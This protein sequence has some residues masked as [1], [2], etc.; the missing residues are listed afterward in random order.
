VSIDDEAIVTREQCRL[1]SWLE[2]R[3]DNEEIARSAFKQAFNEL[4]M[5]RE[6]ESLAVIAE[7]CAIPAGFAP[8]RPLDGHQRHQELDWIE[9]GLRRTYLSQYAGRHIVDDRFVVLHLTD[10]VRLIV[11]SLRRH[12]SRVSPVDR[13]SVGAV[14]GCV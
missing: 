7:R 11:M 1:L 3:R 12:A 2:V 5:S 8:T 9:T 13:L 10:D 6:L 14:I 4:L